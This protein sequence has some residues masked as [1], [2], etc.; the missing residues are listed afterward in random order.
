MRLG[1]KGPIFSHLIYAECN[2]ETKQLH[3]YMHLDAIQVNFK[4]ICHITGPFRLMNITLLQCCVN[5]MDSPTFKKFQGE[6]NFLVEDYRHV[7]LDTFEN[8]F[9]VLKL[10]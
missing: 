9:C 3:S 7:N 8:C 5:V 2:I 1:K 10:I 4:L 6:I